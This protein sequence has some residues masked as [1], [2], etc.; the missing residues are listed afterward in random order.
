MNKSVICMWAYLQDLFFSWGVSLEGELWMASVSSSCQLLQGLCHPVG[1]STTKQGVGIL[2][3]FFLRSPVSKH[4]L[5]FFPLPLL[6]SCSRG[7]KRCSVCSRNRWRDTLRVT[8]CF[9]EPLCSF[10]FIS[11]GWVSQCSRHLLCEGLQNWAGKCPAG[12]CNSPGV[13]ACFGAGWWG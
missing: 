13:T 9:V 10:P 11:S 8:L 5:L 3:V 1:G 4:E 7:Q 2:N 12:W 6:Y